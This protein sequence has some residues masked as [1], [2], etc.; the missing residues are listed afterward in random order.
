MRY[1]LRF[2]FYDGERLHEQYSIIDLVEGKQPSTATPVGPD[3]KPGAPTLED[4]N[5]SKD[6]TFNPDSAEAGDT[7]SGLT[8]KK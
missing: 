1:R 3:D 5:P 4:Y 6:P 8:K 2:P 7:L